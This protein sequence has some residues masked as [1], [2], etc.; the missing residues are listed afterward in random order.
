MPTAEQDAVIAA[1]AARTPEGEW[2]WEVYK[3]VYQRGLA[4][5]QERLRTDARA[6]HRAMDGW[7]RVKDQ[8][9]WVEMVQQADEGLA[10]GR[11][12]VDHLGAERY[13]EPELMATLIALRRRLVCEHRVS[14][15][16]DLL[17]VDSALIAW[18]HT[19]R[20]NGW[21]GNFALLIEH[22]FFQME[23]PTAKLRKRYGSGVESLKAEDMVLRIGEQLLPLLDRLNRLMLRNLRA[24]RDPRQRPAPNVTIGAAGQVNVGAPQV[25]V[26]EAGAADGRA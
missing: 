26:A 23:G 9:A 8:A 13:L 20:I 7:G 4:E 14:S 19:L 11:F 3:E 10:T 16:A 5:R 25:N 12:L 1:K 21:I 2:D 17:L 6:S 22:E 24:L 18:Y 15:A